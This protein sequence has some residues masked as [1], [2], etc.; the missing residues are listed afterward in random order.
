[1]EEC[2][3]CGLKKKFYM[4][5]HS[6]THDNDDLFHDWHLELQDWMHHPIV[7]HAEIMGYIMYYHQVIKQH[8]AK[9][10]VNAI[11]KEGNGHVKAK[12]WKLIKH[13]EVPIGT[14]VIPSIWAMHC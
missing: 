10:F 4:A 3:F 6:V 12:C 1:M 7:F 14:D 5:A 2:Y 8:D 11:V 13:T 9:D